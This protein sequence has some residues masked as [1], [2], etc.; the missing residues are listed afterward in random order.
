MAL[1][2]FA[3]ELVPTEGM[4]VMGFIIGL[5]HVILQV[6]ISRGDVT[7]EDD[8]EVAKQQEYMVEDEAAK[9]KTITASMGGSQPQGLPPRDFGRGGQRGPVSGSYFGG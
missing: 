4:T 2:R 9:K 3:P 6:I 5:K 7:L 8:I 1:W